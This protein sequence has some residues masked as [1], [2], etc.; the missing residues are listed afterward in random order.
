[1]STLLERLTDAQNAH[2]VELFAS[3]LVPDHRSEQ[4]AH[5][6]EQHDQDIGAG[7]EQLHRPPGHDS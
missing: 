6:V 5:P 2:D 1:M 7:V 4:A 3:C